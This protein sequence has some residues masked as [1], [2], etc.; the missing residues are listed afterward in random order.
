[1]RFQKNSV[2]KHLTIDEMWELYNLIG[3]SVKDKNNYLIDEISSMLDDLSNYE[4]I[5]SLEL[6]YKEVSPKDK[7]PVTL[8]TMFVSGL[9]VNKFF[10]FH[11]F[12]KGLHGSS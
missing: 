5:K 9:K 3:S 12:I 4:F 10:E 6:M 1:M 2:P 11:D 7:N 8:L